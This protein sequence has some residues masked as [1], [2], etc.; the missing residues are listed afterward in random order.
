MKWK[1]LIVPYL[2][3]YTN[4]KEKEVPWAKFSGFVSVNCKSFVF[5]IIISKTVR[6]ITA[7]YDGS[8]HLN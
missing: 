2:H 3:L 8:N 6:F 7:I 1:K 5:L 4:L